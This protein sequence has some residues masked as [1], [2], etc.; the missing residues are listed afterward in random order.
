M[1]KEK[2]EKLPP[3]K[4]EDIHIGCLNC[5]T[6]T[7]EASM[8]MMIAVGFGTAMITK[9]GEL[10][11]DGEKDYHDNGEPKRLKEIEEIAAKDPDNDWRFIKHGPMHGET[12][13]RQDGK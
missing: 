1:T 2:W 12:F 13:Q 9:N 8:D 6:A 3:I 4:D 7:P 11:Y 10:F 5:S